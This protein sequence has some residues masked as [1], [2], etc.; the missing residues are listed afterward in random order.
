MR[1]L[2]AELDGWDGTYPDAWRP[3]AGE[4]LVGVVK[5][6]TTA[7]NQYGEVAV[8]TVSEEETGK[9]VAVWLSSAVLL[10]LYKR[11]KP[12]VGERIGL[13]YGGTHPEKGYKL[14]ALVVDRPEEAEPDFDSLIGD[15]D[16]PEEPDPFSD[17][18]SAS[19]FGAALRTRAGRT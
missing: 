8:C 13:K 9:A 15:S 10:S 12:K 5:N 7:E 19:A 18:R 16:A 3:R 17:T 11:H 1:D 6:Y 4:T 2:R 14:Y